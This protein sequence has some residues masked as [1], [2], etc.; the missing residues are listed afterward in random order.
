[1]KKMLL[2]LLVLAFGVAGFF[3]NSV[4][5][6]LENSAMMV[7]NP[8]FILPG[9]AIIVLVFAV[10][11]VKRLLIKR[12]LEISDDEMRL[13]NERKRSAKR[14]IKLFSITTLG[15]GYLL[16][17]ALRYLFDEMAKKDELV[18]FRADGEIKAIMRGD[19]CIRYL[20]KVENHRIDPDGFDIF[21]GSLKSYAKH[22]A[23]A[24]EEKKKEDS[25]FEDKK[26]W[27][28]EHGEPEL[29]PNLKRAIEEANSTTLFEE[30]FGVYW[31]GF[32][33]YRVFK[34]KFRWLK[35]G[36]KKADD[37]GIPSD[38]IEVHAREDMVDSLYFRYPQYALRFSGFETG[39]G[40]MG[41]RIGSKEKNGLGDKESTVV[42]VKGVLV[43]E[44]VT[45]NPQKTLFRTAALS[46]AGDWQQALVREILDRFRKWLGTTT[47]DDLIREEEK[48]RKRLS[49][50]AEEISNE[51]AIRDYGQRIARISMPA[52]DLEDDRLQKAHNEVLEQEK[53]RDAN[54][55]KAEGERALAGARIKGEADGFFEIG[56]ANGGTEM[57]IAQQLGKLQGV[58]A[59]SR[60]GIF[61]NISEKAT[62]VRS[63]RP[64]KEPEDSPEEKGQE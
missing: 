24:A 29:Q 44:T 58:Y 2:F 62:G 19:T 49:D 57:Y 50:L 28:N 14:I 21:K 45:V 1:M 20:M 5:N 40:K 13:T 26:I 48:I 52:I 36:Q 33:P 35:Y 9:A 41:E 43:F 3:W 60:D 53:K 4:R 7:F 54:M 31:I 30:L 38:Q 63:P 34:Y 39:A 15:S 12:D 55:A 10:F 6:F 59:P 64:A 8:W 37:K 16:Y 46:S 25:G 17:L 47:W 22:L 32:A 61:L 11:L 23:K 42:Q 27:S 51:V 18:T 56:K